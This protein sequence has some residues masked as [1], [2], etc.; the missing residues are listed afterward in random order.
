MEPIAR[1]ILAIKGLR[2]H[3]VVPGSVLLICLTCGEFALAKWTSDSGGEMPLGSATV[4]ALSFVSSGLF[5]YVNTMLFI[6]LKQDYR[7][8]SMFA[9]RADRRSEPAEHLG[10]RSEELLEGHGDRKGQ[11]G[12][13]TDPVEVLYSWNGL[14]MS[15]GGS[16][17]ALAAF[18]LVQSGILDT[19]S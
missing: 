19:D 15:I 11:P 18:G 1:G 13:R 8:G 7:D 4:V 17:G 16:V 3:I 5:S 12:G 9:G 14:A 6:E 10:G 2:F